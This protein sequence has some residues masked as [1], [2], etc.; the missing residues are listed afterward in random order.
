MNPLIVLFFLALSLEDYIF[1]NG[2][3]LKYYFYSI[4]IYWIFYILTPSSQ[5]NT[6]ERKLALAGYSNSTDPTVYGKLK[7]EITKAKKFLDNLNNKVGKK[8]T[9]TLFTTKV[10]ALCIQKFPEINNAIKFGKLT[11]RGTIDI[12]LLV[13]V[14][15]GKVNLK[16]FKKK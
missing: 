6:A 11:N 10:F 2:F 9:W 3:L 12:S 8:I 4:I 7:P 16:F 15:E 14:K 5:Y 13:N 1:R